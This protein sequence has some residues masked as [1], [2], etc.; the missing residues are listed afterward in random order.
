[1]RYLNKLLI[2][3][4]LWASLLM[5]ACSKNESYELIMVDN[6]IYPI[7]KSFENSF[8]L[9]FWL[10]PE[11]QRVGSVI[12]TIEDNNQEVSLLANSEDSNYLNTGI[13]LVHENGSI[14][15]DG[16][17]YLE[18]ANFN[19]VVI[20][21]Y[22][23]TFFLYLNG[24]KV[25]DKAFGEPFNLD[26]IVIKLGSDNFKGT[27]KKLEI[28]EGFLNDETIYNDFLSH[29]DYL[30]TN[31]DYPSSFKNNPHG[32]IALPKSKWPI[33]YSSDSD[34]IKFDDRYIYFESVKEDEEIEL[35]AKI[36]IDG[37]TAIKRI[38]FANS[39]SKL[40]EATQIINNRIGHIVSES[41]SFPVE[42][43]G[44]AIDYK[45]LN[46]NAVFENGHFVKTSDDEKTNVSAEITITKDEESNIFRKDFVLLDEYAAYLLVCFDGHDG[47][48]EHITGEESIYLAYSDDLKTFIKLNE[49]KIINSDIGSNRFRDPH[50]SRDE[51][52]NFI[53]AATEGYDNP[54][55]YL[56]RSTDMIDFEVKHLDFTVNDRSIG[57]N[58]LKSYAP[59]IV[60]NHNLNI[61]TIIY[62]EPSKETV[63]LFAVDTK[64]FE[65]FS[66]PYLYFD[67]GY[68]VI[69]GNVTEIDGKYY[70][71]YKDED[72]DDIY[73]AI[74][75]TLN[76]PVWDIYD[77]TKLN[78]VIC[79]GPFL[80]K[81]E[82]TGENYLYV[83]AYRNSAIYSSIADFGE[84]FSVDV[85]L[86]KDIGITDIGGV[87]HFSI[88]E[89]T[90][91]EKM[92]I[93]D[94]YE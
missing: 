60:Y 39:Y 74:S 51:N 35:T 33:E 55:I 13:I 34:N 94:Y 87:R 50:I 90:E 88:I 58:G 7:E 70:L 32:K 62:S 93:L 56:V 40:D 24:E 48:P 78:P 59:E 20:N 27:F 36:E 38:I 57:L 67:A 66:Q 61:Y 29:L 10:K 53:I 85:N 26:D 44:Y 68:N 21:Y 54:G 63:G 4:L 2:L 81:S 82:I 83:D 37:H 41:A 49:D 28:S 79:E 45:I 22:D 30:L 75:D 14:Y 18:T 9:S 5:T 42:Y 8:S 1:M 69:D 73:Y 15:Q 6:D 91:K 52:G 23:N 89:I 92:R 86:S 64:D 17:K 47:W 11:K 80:L 65:D 46:G 31:I 16:S 71:F 72:N 76:N 3:L 43:K 77:A 84:E 12:L 25:G 19:H